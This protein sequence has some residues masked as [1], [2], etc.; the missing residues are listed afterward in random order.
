MQRHKSHLSEGRLRDDNIGFEFLLLLLSFL[1]CSF[2]VSVYLFVCLF[3][4]L[5]AFKFSLR[6]ILKPLLL[7]TGK[8]RCCDIYYLQRP[9]SRVQIYFMKYVITI[10]SELYLTRKAFYYSTLFRSNCEVACIC[11]GNSTTM[12]FTATK[13]LQ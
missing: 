5:I 2:L 8:I 3:V 11:K 7:A 6:R 10:L 4:V 1:F 12:G 9:K 13:Y